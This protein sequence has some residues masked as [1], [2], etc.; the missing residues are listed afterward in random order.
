MTIHPSDKMAWWLERPLESEP[1]E[2]QLNDLAMIAAR[3]DA[4]RQFFEKSSAKL[5]SLDGY[6]QWF[7]K[8]DLF[9]VSYLEVDCPEL[10]LQS[11]LKSILIDPTAAI[12]FRRWELSDSR[13]WAAFPLS[14]FVPIEG[15]EV[16]LLHIGRKQ[17]PWAVSAECFKVS[18]RLKNGG[19]FAVMTFHHP[20]LHMRFKGAQ[21]AEDGM[22][23]R[24]TTRSE[25]RSALLSQV[26]DRLRGS[27]VTITEPIEA[28]A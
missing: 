6:F 16:P 24:E 14:A 7:N 13:A 25:L 22:F 2:S 18:H 28:I 15:Q 19:R 1:F 5:S 27:L 17:T 10:E 20:D 8:H 11:T 23:P 3:C 21:W 12:E 4:W 26:R 9:S